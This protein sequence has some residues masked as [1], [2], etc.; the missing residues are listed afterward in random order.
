MAQFSQWTPL[1]VVDGAAAIVGIC[2]AVIE[3]RIYQAG[4]ES[5]I[6]RRSLMRR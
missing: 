5:E 1:V 3:A 2:S 4:V 6:A